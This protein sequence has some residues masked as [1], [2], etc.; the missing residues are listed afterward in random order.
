MNVRV[1]AEVPDERGAFQPPVVPQAVAAEI[2]D[3]GLA[4]LKGLTNLGSLNLE[5]TQ[6][7]DAG[8][9]ELRKALPNC[10]IRY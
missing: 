4:G 10:S 5:N 8:V 1:A 3:A 7:T 9:A 6:V 2:T